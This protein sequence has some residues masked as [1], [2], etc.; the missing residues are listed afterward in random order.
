MFS[1][2]REASQYLQTEY[3][4]YADTNNQMTAALASL[5]QNQEYSSLIQQWIDEFHK[6][7]GNEKPDYD[8]MNKTIRLAERVNNVNDNDKNQ[9]EYLSTDAVEKNSWEYCV[10]AKW[11]EMMNWI[12]DVKTKEDLTEKL[13]EMT[14]VQQKLTML[15]K[16]ANSKNKG[17][18]NMLLRKFQH[19]HNVN[20]RF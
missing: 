19:W 3:N 18:S 12:N 20:K 9:H 15:D 14:T 6:K 16:I 10:D 13:A 11:K 5:Q 17:F 2:P 1:N 4:M 7:Y 8:I